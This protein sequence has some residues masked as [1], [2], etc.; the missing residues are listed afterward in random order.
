MIGDIVMNFL[1]GV[2]PWSG[3]KADK[4]KEKYKLMKEKKGFN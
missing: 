1:R 4:K 2:L 3:L